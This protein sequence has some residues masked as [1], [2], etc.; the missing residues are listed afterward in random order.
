MEISLEKLEDYKK[1][2]H[3][4]ETTSIN[5]TISNDF[6][7]KFTIEKKIKQ[8]LK[9]NITSIDIKLKN[10]FKNDFIF[11]L[12]SLQTIEVL[13]LFLEPFPKQFG[14]KLK[15]KIKE[16]RNL[17]RISYKNS[18]G[19]SFI[20]IE[21]LLS[22]LENVS[23][24]NLQNVKMCNGYRI[25][26]KSVLEKLTLNNCVLEDYFSLFI[27][28]KDISIINC[29][30]MNMKYFY[31]ALKDNLNIKKIHFENS[32][33]IPKTS[34]FLFQLL[35]EVPVDNLVI[36]NLEDI[37]FKQENTFIYK[38][39]R[40]SI[41]RFHSNEMDQKFKFIEKSKYL[42]ELEIDGMNL[43]EKDNFKLSKVLLNLNLKKL[44]YYNMIHGKK[45]LIPYVSKF[46]FFSIE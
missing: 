3:T 25:T 22:E 42:E 2:R 23:E 26:S 38:L 1:L 4:N 30:F 15:E 9:K 14:I 13:N 11:G 43:C 10:A 34:S 40:L 31:E 28:V 36:N 18:M 45:I 7:K 17:K 41:L 20:D 19:L 46:F 32:W 29:R 8:F 5:L 27:N 37:S 33:I 39:K 12:L 16:L 21:D 24:L 6:I 35:S 44:A